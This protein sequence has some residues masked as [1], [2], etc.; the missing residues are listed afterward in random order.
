MAKDQLKEK[1]KWK[2]LLIGGS[3]GAL[4]VVLQ[5][6][7]SLTP[8]MNVSALVILHRKSTEENVLL[9]VL[10]SKT[11]MEVRETE[12]KDEMMPGVLYIAPADYHVLIER[13]GTMTLDDSE[14]I[15]YSRPSIDVSFESAAEIYGPSLV[16]VL[17]SGANADGVGGLVAARARGAKIVVQ[18]PDTAEFV[19]MPR[20]A[21]AVLK[22]DL[23]LTDKNMNEL[24]ELLKS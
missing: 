18:D 6:V 11:K 7:Q 1:R 19:Y 16:C 5:I 15:N 10:T 23:V 4:T 3:A 20:Q 22:P 8:A 17:L 13:D 14:K 2:T 24:Y 21:M 12:D 9:D